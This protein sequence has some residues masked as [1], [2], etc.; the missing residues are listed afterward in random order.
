[1]C[2]FFSSRESDKNNFE[3]SERIKKLLFLRGPDQQKTLDLEVGTFIFN[4]LAIID[5]NERSSQPMRSED[6]IRCFC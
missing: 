5:V 6:N 3:L 4:R 1:M 2:G